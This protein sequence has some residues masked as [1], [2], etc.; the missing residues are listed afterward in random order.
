MLNKSKTFKFLI[1]TLSVAALAFAM[2]VSAADFGSVTLKVG[3]K[4]EAVKTLQVLVGA[5]PV[6]GVFGNMTKA[7]VM[8]WQAANGLTADGV[9]GPASKAKAAGVV[10]TPPTGGTFPAG[11]T[12]AAGFSTTT[13]ASCATVSTLPAGCTSTAGFSST[14]GASCSGAA[15]STGALTGS[16]G[17][18]TVTETSTDVEDPAIEGQ[19][20]KVLGFKVEASDSDVAIKTLKVTLE[21]TDAPGSSYR[22]ANYVNSVDIMMGSTKVGSAD[23]ADFAKDGY[24]YSKSIALSDAV[25]KMGSSKKATFYVVINA[26]TNIDSTDMT[27]SRWDIDVSNIRFQDATGVIMTSDSLTNPS[28]TGL[29][30]GDLVSSG[31]VKM[32]ISKGSSSPIS[33]NVEVS[34]TSSTS[35]VLMLEFKLKATGSDLSFDQL[36]FDLIGSMVTEDL[37]TMIS[38]MTLKKGS[39]VLASDPTFS[40]VTDMT[41]TAE[42]TLDDT[43]TV[44]EGTTDTFRVYAKIAR[45]DAFNSG[46]SLKVFLASSGIAPEDTNGDIVQTPELSGSATGTVQTF[47][48]Q[49]AVVTYVSDSFVAED[50]SGTT[51]V[52][53]TI[54]MKFKVTA[55]GDS[56][57]TL[58][59][60]GSDLTYDIGDESEVSAILTSSDLTADGSDFIIP[61]GDTATFTLSVKYSGTDGFVQLELNDVAGTEV[62][63]IKTAAH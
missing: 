41:S 11:C 19:A 43:Y 52:N 9:F 23:A 33:G 62:S 38:D 18:I 42:F 6:D 51:P 24:S 61:A 36:T 44:A 15:V 16:A 13:G 53:G 48:S 40:S 54:S 7:K 35:D 4:G 10:V 63:N 60:D 8:V 25:V 12:S 50:L 57:I 58:A 29:E 26:A 30:F 14:T 5:T 47:L 22:L 2:V 45:L 21:N 59:D 34:D 39:D 20:T 46:D 1:G 49:G 55:F 28:I 37:S 17:E 56:E 32:A 3:S 27:D 31:D